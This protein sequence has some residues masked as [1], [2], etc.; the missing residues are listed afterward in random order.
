VQPCRELDVL[1]RRQ[2]RVE[3]A[4]V[5]D[6]P[7]AGPRGGPAGESHTVDPRLARR[8]A[9]QPGEQAQQRRLSRSVRA[10]EGETVAGAER[11]RD[12]IDRA[13]GAEGAREAGRLDEERRMHARGGGAPGGARREGWHAP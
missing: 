10:E 1:A 7:D 12:V 3:H 6:Q 5:R 13:A 9:E 4:L 8:R 2:R 11:E